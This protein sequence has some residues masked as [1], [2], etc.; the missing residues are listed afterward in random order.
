MKTFLFIILA[1]FCTLFSSSQ[2]LAGKTTFIQEST[3]A[4]WNGSYYATVDKTY[5]NDGNLAAGLV[6]ITDSLT[7]LLDSLVTF[8]PSAIT[9]TG[10][11]YISVYKDSLLD[12]VIIRVNGKRSATY[13]MG[14]KTNHVYIPLGATFSATVP[15][16]QR[17]TVVFRYRKTVTLKRSSTIGLNLRTVQQ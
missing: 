15:G 16:Y 7:H 1:T 13:A 3:I 14:A 17:L 9:G 2:I 5:P 4:H 8:V 6:V 11:M 12:T 10:S